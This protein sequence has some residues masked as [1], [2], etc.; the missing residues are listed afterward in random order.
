MIE[1]FNLA[2]DAVLELVRR[3]EQTVQVSFYRLKRSLFRMAVELI[4][5]SIA[6]IFTLTGLIL[7]ISKYF[8]IEW[9]I[10]LIGLLMLN[11]SLLMIRF[12]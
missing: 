1:I 3:G 12:R 8:P 5:F 7:V 9:V 4:I 2:K 6:V 10:L 11:A